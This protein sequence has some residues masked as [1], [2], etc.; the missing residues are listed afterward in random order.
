MIVQACLLGHVGHHLLKLFEV[1]EP[2]FVLVHSL[3]EVKPGVIIEFT[4]DL[5]KIFD[6]DL[7]MRF[8]VEEVESFSEFLIWMRVISAWAEKGGGPP[9]IDVNKAIFVAVHCPHNL[10]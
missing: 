1:Q 5:S 3:N 9:L 7:S 4:K 8:F 10:V 6:G 2:I